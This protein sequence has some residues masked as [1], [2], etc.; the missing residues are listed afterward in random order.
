MSKVDTFLLLSVKMLVVLTGKL[1]V[2]C[3]Q[4]VLVVVIERVTFLDSLVVQLPFVMA[5]AAVE[6]VED[7]VPQE[8]PLT[9]SDK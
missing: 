1:V 9:G 3:L 4:L 6:L 7:Q 2:Q 5:L 8:L